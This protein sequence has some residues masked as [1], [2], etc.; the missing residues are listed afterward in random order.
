[1]VSVMYPSMEQIDAFLGRA[2]EHRPYFMCEYCH[3]MGNGSGDLETY[4]RKIYAEPRMMGG[5]IWEWC[6]H[7]IQVGLTADGKPR[8]AYGGD[9]D[10][11]AHDGKFCLD[12]PVFPDQTPH[13]GLPEV[14]ALNGDNLYIRFRFLLRASRPWM[15]EG[16]EVCF[17]QLA[18]SSRIMTCSPSGGQGAISVSQHKKRS[19]SG[20]K[21]SFVKWICPQVCRP[22][23]KRTASRCWMCPWHTTSGARL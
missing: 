21:I 2:H 3:A 20:V 17:D 9:F 10:E 12:G 18:L 15:D 13:G 16:E 8:Y 1:M 4:W 11:P 19:R 7:G 5:C 22:V 6:D 14:A 23:G